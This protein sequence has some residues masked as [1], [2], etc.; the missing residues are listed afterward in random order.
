[1]VAALTN[2]AIAIVFGSVFRQFADF[3]AGNIT[4]SEFLHNIA[5]YC[6]YLTAFGCLSWLSNSISCMAFM[7]FGELQ[8]HSARD[9]IFISLLRK[10]MAWYDTRD[11]GI[12]ALLPSVQ[13]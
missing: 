5:K 11:T 4:A 7:A 8:A 10:D 2:P 6:T 9:M 3:G 12:A 1:L 13:M